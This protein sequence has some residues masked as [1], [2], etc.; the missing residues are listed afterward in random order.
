[1]FKTRAERLPLKALLGPSRYKSGR[2]QAKLLGLS[3]DNE[4]DGIDRSG[5]AE[6]LYIKVEDDG[7][8]CG[9]YKWIRP[10]FL[11]TVIAAQ[12]HWK[13]R[14][15]VVNALDHPHQDRSA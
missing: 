11:A 2:W 7:R 9:R 13:D 12:R 14:G 1:M 6:G 8:V 4:T 3:A 5:D 15:M 10:S